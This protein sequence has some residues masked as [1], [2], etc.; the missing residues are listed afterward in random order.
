MVEI[1]RVTLVFAGPCPHWPGMTGQAYASLSCYLQLPLGMPCLPSQTVRSSGTG[2]W[3]SH[4]RSSLLPCPSPS[5]ISAPVESL[6]LAPLAGVS[7]VPMM[8]G[9]KE[10]AICAQ[11]QERTAEGCDKQELLQLTEQVWTGG[12]GGGF[13]GSTAC[14]SRTPSPA[15]SGD[16][17]LLPCSRKLFGPTEP[18]FSHL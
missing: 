11:P 13:L 16:L 8:R 15:E 10:K 5:P 9:D 18:Q 3:L 14:S 2:P 4:P 1:Q 6:A 7:S 17:A 12:G